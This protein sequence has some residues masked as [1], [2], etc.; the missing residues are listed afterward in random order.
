MR[1]NLSSAKMVAIL[2]RRRWV[3]KMGPRRQN[4]KAIQRQRCAF[5]LGSAAPHSKKNIHSSSSSSF[6]R[7]LTLWTR[8][9][10]EWNLRKVI[11]TLISVI[12]GRGTSCKIALRWMS[13]DLPVDKSTMVRV[14]IWCRQATSI[15]RNQ[16]W[17]GSLSHHGV[18]RPHCVKIN[19]PWWRHTI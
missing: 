16:Y 7:M 17:P 2:T 4:K 18:T 13:L 3:N 6:F 8:G 5:F 11:L 9:S 15:Y 19:D 1:L 12:R 14:M 10:F